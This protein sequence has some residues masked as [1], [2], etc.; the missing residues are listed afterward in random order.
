[1]TTLEHVYA[2]KNILSHGSSSDDFS[3]SNN[4][5]LHYLEV[6]RAKLIKEKAD[7]YQ[8]ISELSFQSLCMDL[9][10]DTFHN[11]CVGPTDCKVLKT[12]E[13]V[14]TTLNSRWGDLLK[15]MTLDGTVIPKAS[16][17]ESNLSQFSLVKTSPVSYYVYDGCIVINNNTSLSKIIVNGIFNTPSVPIEV[18][19]STDTTTTCKS[20]MEE[21]FP[22]DAD[23]VAPMY[24]LALSYLTSTQTKDNEQDAKDTTVNG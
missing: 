3:Y 15:V 22:I 8:Y 12:V 6:A 2:I 11:C 10:L 19:C 13:K 18:S 7:K 16:K 9:H 4:L 5:I 24:Q 1:M 20:Y 17:T 21:I 23:L 14:P